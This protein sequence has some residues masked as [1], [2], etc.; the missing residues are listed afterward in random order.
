MLFHNINAIAMARR[1]SSTIV[2]LTILLWQCGGWVSNRGDD[3]AGG[4]LLVIMMGGDQVLAAH[5]EV[6]VM[7][8]WAWDRHC[9]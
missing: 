2:P 5:C 9:Y 4:G 1:S 3:I 6:S 7:V 8:V